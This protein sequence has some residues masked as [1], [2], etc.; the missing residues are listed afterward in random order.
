MRLRALWVWVAAG[1]M[2]IAAAGA[3]LAAGIHPHWG[4]AD[5]GLRLAAWLHEAGRRLPA[6][7]AVPI[8]AMSAR[9]RSRRRL[10]PRRDAQVIAAARP[11]VS[12][13]AILFALAAI[14]LFALLAMRTLG[15]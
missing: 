11:A 12:P 2:I 7:L 9:Q 10:A 8:V 5:G 3:T 4:V 14:A 13:Y 15:R 6:A 1:C